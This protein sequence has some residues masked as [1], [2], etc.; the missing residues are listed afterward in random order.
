[1]LRP[2]ISPG[3]GPPHGSDIPNNMDLMDLKG[4]NGVTWFSTHPAHDY[5]LLHSLNKLILT[6]VLPSERYYHL[7]FVEKSEV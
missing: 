3:E 4:A 5:N 2:T 7:N 6:T 1:M